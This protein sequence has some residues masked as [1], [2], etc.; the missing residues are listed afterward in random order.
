M[1]KPS[2]HRLITYWLT[3]L[4]ISL[5]VAGCQ[6]S[7]SEPLPTR[8]FLAPADTPVPTPILLPAKALTPWETISSSMTAYQIE[9]WTFTATAGDAI[10]LRIASR[11]NVSLN[12]RD[13]GGVL[14][15][16]GTEIALSIPADGTY[17]VDVELSNAER[18]NYEMAL[19]YTDRDNPF[20]ATPLPE[21]VG[22]PTPTL[23]FGELGTFQAELTAG[24]PILREIASDQA[25]IYI[26][27]VTAGE[28]ASFQL[29]AIGEGDP[30]LRLYDPEEKVVA[31]DDDSGPGSNATIRNITF[32]EAGIYS[33]QVRMKAG[34]GYELNASIGEQALQPDT[35]IT[36]TP[37]VAAAY[38]A[39]PLGTLDEE[40]RLQDHVPVLGELRSGS[41]FGRYSFYGLPGQV[42][43]IGLSPHSES[44][45][46]PV[47]EI[48][49]PDGS[50]LATASGRNSNARGAALVRNITLPEEGAYLVIVTSEDGTAG[51]YTLGY[52]LG[53]S[54][55]ESYVGDPS[56]DETFS[57]T[58][59]AVGTRD[60][61]R[62]ILHAGDAISVAVNPSASSPIDPVV[63]LADG[64]GNVLYRDDNGGTNRSALIRYAQV[65]VDGSYWLYVYDA[66]VEAAGDYSLRWRIVDAAPTPTAVPVASTILLVNDSVTE[67]DYGFYSFY[68]HADDRVQIQ[69]TAADT[70]RLDPVAVLLDP[71][72]QEIAEGDDDDGLNPRFS[73]TL[74]VDGTYTVR[75]NGYLSGGDFELK[76]A[77]VIE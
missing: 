19:V 11:E 31:M 57:R 22:V 16:S 29:N 14:L 65:Q 46:R 47:I 70:Q 1:T 62:V 13:D 51:S 17:T 9:R 23:R 36:P 4:A 38:S 15:G 20:A 55:Q 45:I 72:G 63:E 40:D 61:Y 24:E 77:V 76:V 18:A 34:G 12:L 49:A 69:V 33:L 75:V 73:A 64:D 68:G 53:S 5:V 58:L 56:A 59:P 67:G 41:D 71:S 43:T 30:V 48:I 37:F 39:P 8:A 10:R 26:Y 42:V 21:V 66:A 60:V 7:T 27:E 32:A 54:Y 28:T 6:P 25:H 52:G 50:V 3:T 2:P 74:P 35:I 44:N